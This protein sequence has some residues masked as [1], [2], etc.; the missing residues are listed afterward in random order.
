[1]PQNMI[2]ATLIA[3]GVTLSAGG[4]AEAAKKKSH[5]IEHSASQKL[6][7][8]T[9]RSRTVPGDTCLGADACNELIAE[10]IGA[11]LDFE[12][13]RHD[14]PN[15]EPTHGWCVKRTD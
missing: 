11:G 3:F 10:C 15:G 8:P 14:G 4:Q 6:K 5:S 9:G 13:Q 7:A 12:P 1:M 2:L